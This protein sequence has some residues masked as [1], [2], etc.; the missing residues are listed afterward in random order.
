[1][2]LDNRV[3]ALVSVFLGTWYELRARLRMRRTSNNECLSPD[4]RTTQ[5]GLAHGVIVVDV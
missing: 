1:M 2:L 5:L 4:R 3:V